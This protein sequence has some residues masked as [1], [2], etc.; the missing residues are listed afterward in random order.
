[1]ANGVT[2]EYWI[3]SPVCGGPPCKIRGLIGDEREAK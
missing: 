1:M 3:E 2:M